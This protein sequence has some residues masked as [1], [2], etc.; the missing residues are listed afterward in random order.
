MAKSDSGRTKRDVAP[1][2]PSDYFK[3]KYDVRGGYCFFVMPFAKEFNDVYSTI[4][5]ALQQEELAVEC[6]RADEIVGGGEVMAD[7]LRNLAEAE[8]IIVDLTGD[9]PN[10]FYELGIAHTLRCKEAVVLIRQTT[11]DVSLERKIPFDVQHYRRIPYQPGPDGLL[12]LGNKLAEM[13]RNDILPTRFTFDL[14]EG[15]SS[16]P[17]EIS[18]EDGRS[19]Y[20][21]QICD[22]HLTRDRAARFRL[23]VHQH[24]SEAP[25]R[26]FRPRPCG[27]DEQ[28]RS[29]HLSQRDR[30]TL[31]ADS[32]PTQPEGHFRG[33]SP[34]TGRKD[35]NTQDPVCTEIARGK[36]WRRGL[37]RLSPR[38]ASGLSSAP[39]QMPNRGCCVF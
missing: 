1:M 14:G 35:Q 29:R 16:Q 39:N 9:N 36:I 4:R 13:V 21:F 10:V 8:L 33:A 23:D 26:I 20:S 34:T 37:L 18:G 24:E 25:I 2:H 32:P 27:A 22:V 12:E 6:H 17:V 31:V 38:A 7:V 5:S 15:E 11:A 28:S 3:H 19:S 30:P